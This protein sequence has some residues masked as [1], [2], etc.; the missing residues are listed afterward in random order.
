[1]PI[2]ELTYPA[3]VF[4]R[5]GPSP[6]NAGV[7]GAP[8][9]DPPRTRVF[10]FWINIS[11]NSRS[12][13]VTPTLRGPVIIF[14]YTVSVDAVGDPPAGTLEIGWKAVPGH[15]AAVPLATLRPYTV[16]TELGDL[17]NG[18]ND[19]AGR[20]FLHNT[21]QSP[22]LGTY[23]PIRIVIDAPEVCVVM[24]EVNNSG[25]VMKSSGYLHLVENVSREALAFFL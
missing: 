6:N 7:P 17:Q 8:G 19:A 10:P 12:S 4:D 2:D 22:A 5:S 3:P 13:F 11:A 21:P 14:G 1:M 18:V 23:V 24:A 20:G 9:G 16:L 25:F 15:E